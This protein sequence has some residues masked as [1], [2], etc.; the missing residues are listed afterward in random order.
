MASHKKLLL[1]GS[2]IF[3]AA[4]AFFFG[5]TSGYNSISDDY[6]LPDH[7]IPKHYNIKIIPLVELRYN[8]S[9]LLRSTFEEPLFIEE[10]LNNS[11]IFTAKVDIIIEILRPTHDISFH[12]PKAK[13]Y[14]WSIKVIDSNDK[15]YNQIQYHYDY[16][17]HIL[18]LRFS[19]KLPVGHYTLHMNYTY[20]GKINRNGFF[21][22]SYK[23]K[24]ETS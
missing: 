18:V 20:S 19:E 6:R 5:E 15:I 4:I 23:E 7:I 11:F 14:I 21:K 24:T 12:I 3:I 10:P 22:T 17:T 13:L 16:I 2:L 9:S 8:E 1:N